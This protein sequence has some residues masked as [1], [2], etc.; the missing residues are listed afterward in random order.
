MNIIDFTEN[1]IQ[2]NNYSNDRKNYINTEN[3]RTN[4]LIDLNQMEG[5]TLNTFTINNLASKTIM[6]N[7][8]DLSTELAR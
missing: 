8:I 2:F 6:L 5:K 7:D 1:S 4:F 3:G